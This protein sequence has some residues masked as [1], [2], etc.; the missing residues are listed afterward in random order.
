MIAVAQIIRT[1]TR[2][3]ARTLRE[4]A[5]VGLTDLGDGLSWGEA[6]L[7]IEEYASDPSTHFGAA[8]A[9]WSYPASTPDLISLIAQIRDEKAA[10]GL[11]PWVLA[12]STERQATPDEVA[13]AQAELDA[14]IVF[15]D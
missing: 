1:H 3:I 12:T 14:E 11:M 6:K 5:G 2:P 10:R 8:L 15:S 7:L 4:T 9:G 13:E